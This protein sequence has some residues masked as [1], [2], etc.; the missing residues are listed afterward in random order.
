MNEAQR[1]KPYK[2][3]INGN[4][5]EASSGQTFATYNPAT[6][7]EIAQVARG[8]MADIEQAV[9]AARQALD[10]PW[11]RLKP[12]ERSRLLYA[13]SQSLEQQVD[14]LA[15]LETLDNGKPLPQARKEVLGAARYFEYYAGAAD[16]IHGE[17]I[18]LGPDVVNFTIR[19]AMGVTAHI[20]PWNKP[21]N[22]LARS[23]APAL[24]AGNTAVIK[25]AEQTPLTAL[26]LAEQ[27]AKLDFPAG[28]VNIVTGYGE[29][30]GVALAGHTDI[31]H[32]TFTGSAATGRAVMKAAAEHIKPVVL[33]LGGKSPLIVFAD[34]DLDLVIR[35]AIKGIVTNC[36][37]MCSAGS[38][39]LVMDSVK[40]A[41]LEKLVAAIKQLHIGPGIESPD[42]GP[43]V[44]A[45]QYG[46]VT[47]HI[48]IATSEG[49]HILYGGS[50]PT[51]LPQGYFIEPTLFD[52]VVPD[53]YIAQREV[54][55]PVLSILTFHD[56][57]EALRIANQVPYGLV[58]GIF[59]QDISRALRLATR[60]QAGQIFINEFYTGDEETPFGGYGQS[61]FGR[62][63]GLAALDHYTQIKNVA[64]RLH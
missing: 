17:Q 22:I 40:D 9:V 56:E 38:R 34:A 55:G 45:V 25:P 13:V 24:A 52:N 14:E 21:L 3:F 27:L 28:V 36:G 29:E 49:A 15:R 18:P 5:Q 48:D 12:K 63:K 19:E 51:H 47:G 64:I 11:G 57:V 46:R 61:G 7:A 58:A 59:T 6:E 39:I 54:F 26:K 62:E 41:L 60:I 50:R 35:E 32:L 31:D 53:M 16:K 30:A 23:L 37:Q 2:L 1:Q 8:D 10:G 42:V 20:V 33:E 44:S 4:W 43:L